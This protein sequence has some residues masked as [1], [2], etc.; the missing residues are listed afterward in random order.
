MEQT[1]DFALV[2]FSVVAASAV[3]AQSVKEICKGKRLTKSQYNAVGCCI[4]SGELFSDEKYWSAVGNRKCDGGDDD[5]GDSDGWNSWGGDGI[6][7]G[8]VGWENVKVKWSDSP[9]GWKYC[10]KVTTVFGAAV[11][12]SEKA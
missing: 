7:D 4:Q 8:L 3:V 9:S 1:T 5:D 2:I 6:L 10:V 12:V 11:W